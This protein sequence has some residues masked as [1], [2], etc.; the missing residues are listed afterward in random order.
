[1]KSICSGELTFALA[2]YLDPAPI[3]M[4]SSEEFGYGSR[5]RRYTPVAAPL[6]CLPCLKLTYAKNELYELNVARA[7]QR[8]VVG[9]V[10]VYR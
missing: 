7:G 10:S 8:P 2:L 9:T 6:M 3:S 1:M 5:R 4:M